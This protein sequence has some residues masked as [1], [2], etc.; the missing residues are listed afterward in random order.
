[1]LT[2]AD[3]TYCLPGADL[4]YQGSPERSATAITS[5][6]AGETGSRN[7]TLWEG[8]VEEAPRALLHGRRRN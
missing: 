6:A 8:T 1:M 7:D 3:E 2:R 4:A 5:H